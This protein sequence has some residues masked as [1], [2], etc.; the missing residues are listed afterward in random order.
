MCLTPENFERLCL[1]F[2]Q[3]RVG[4]GQVWR[5]GRPGQDQGGI[6]LVALHRTEADRPRMQTYQCKRIVALSASEMRN[7]VALFLKGPWSQQADAFYLL[8][9]CDV[10][11]A[12]LRDAFVKD[13]RRLLENGIEFEMLGAEE[14][15]DA[16]KTEPRI[17][18]DFFGSPWHDASRAIEIEHR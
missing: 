7:I 3:S 12:R 14:L 2:I 13:H 8:C 6:D 4:S 18:H 1:R 15:S 9:S 10:R 16:L 5:Y 17:V 11:E